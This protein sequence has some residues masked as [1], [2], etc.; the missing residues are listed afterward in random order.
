M[1]VEGGLHALVTL[2]HRPSS[3]HLLL[4]RLSRA[5]PLPEPDIV[6]FLPVRLKWQRLF[7][8]STWSLIP[9]KSCHLLLMECLSRTSQTGAG[10]PSCSLRWAGTSMLSRLEPVS[11][12]DAHSH[13][14]SYWYSLLREVWLQLQKNIW[15]DN[16]VHQNLILLHLLP[17][18]RF[19]STN[20]CYLV[21]SVA[22]RPYKDFLAGRGEK[23]R[24]WEKQK[25]ERG[26]DSKSY[27]SLSHWVAGS[28]K[29]WFQSCVIR[30]F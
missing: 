4:L 24:Q 12:D 5:F 8:L 7:S 11:N 20:D 6:W 29:V 26:R 21:G 23:C 1:C 17:Q 19:V 9:T 22:L 15:L 30:M 27:F 28:V 16:K 18:N 25:A 2:P 13:I 3:P 10:P 14:H